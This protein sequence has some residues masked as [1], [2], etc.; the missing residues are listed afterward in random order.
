M[1]IKTYRIKTG[2]VISYSIAFAY[3]LATLLQGYWKYFFVPHLIAFV[4][5]FSVWLLCGFFTNKITNLSIKTAFREKGILKFYLA[6]E[7]I[8][9][10]ASY[11]LLMQRGQADLAAG[12]WKQISLNVINTHIFGLLAYS[13]M[14]FV[15]Q[16]LN[17]LGQKE[18]M[19]T[20]KQMLEKENAKSKFEALR[21]QLNPHFLFN[22]LTSLKALIATNPVEAEKYV[23]QLSGVYRYLINHRSHDVVLLEDEIEFIQSYLFLLKI[24]YEENLKVAFDIK[25]EYRH[26]RLAPLTLQILLENTV[27][28][29]IISEAS[30]LNIKVF[31]ENDTII[32]SNTLQPRDEV[33]GSSNFGLYNLS[34]QYK[35]LTGNEI[36]IQKTDKEFSVAVPLIAAKE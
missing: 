7:S 3:H 12:N 35:F 5:L 22:S 14:L 4:L 28:H 11:L 10:I 36:E 19:A 6:T 17:V 21:Q 33:E 1:F 16:T 13:F 8:T 26:K 25:D 9:L 20:E 23:V 29:N 24:R 34:Q 18:K 27:K 15:Y 32:V 31:T 2:I 30:P